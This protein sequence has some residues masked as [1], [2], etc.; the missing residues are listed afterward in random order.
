M[1]AVVLGQNAPSL[2]ADARRRPVRFWATAIGL[3]LLPDADV[4]G[5]RFGIAYGDLLGHRGISHSLTFAGVAALLAVLVLFPAERRDFRRSG[6]RLWL[7]FAVVTA[8]HGFLDAFTNGGLG[9]AF[10][11]PWDPERCFFPW[12]PVEVSPL[13]IAQFFSPRGLEVLAS[14]VLWIWVPLGAVAFMQRAFRRARP[15]VR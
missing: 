1:V 9:I 3:S 6:W 5:F 2:A 12:R 10:W 7:F 11:S 14:E 15:P 13:G 4:L 8:S